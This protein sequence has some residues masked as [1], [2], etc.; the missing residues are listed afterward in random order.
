MRAGSTGRVSPELRPDRSKLRERGGG[1]RRAEVNGV[2]L[3]PNRGL[4]P[5]AQGSTRSRAGM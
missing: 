5:A 4:G 1:K 3:Q 2:S